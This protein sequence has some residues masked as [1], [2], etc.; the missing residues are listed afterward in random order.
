MEALQRLMDYFDKRARDARKQATDLEY[1]I[2]QRRTRYVAAEIFGHCASK[3]QE[4][5][6]KKKS[7]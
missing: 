7:E 4:E 3:V 2:G 1:T 5:L 6:N